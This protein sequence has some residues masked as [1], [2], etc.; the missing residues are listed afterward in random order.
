MTLTNSLLDPPRV[1]AFQL[2]QGLVHI[3]MTAGVAKALAILTAGA[4]RRTAWRW[5]AVQGWS[6]APPATRYLRLWLFYL[7]L[8]HWGHRA[9][10]AEDHGFSRP[11]ATAQAVVLETLRASRLGPVTSLPLKGEVPAGTVVITGQ[12]IQDG[13]LPQPEWPMMQTAFALARLK[14]TSSN[15][16]TSAPTGGGGKVLLRPLTCRNCAGGEVR[17]DS[18]SC[19]V[20]GLHSVP[21]R[22]TVQRE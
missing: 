9:R 19:V 5:F 4:Y 15:T 1:S 7:C 6:Q 3:A 16:S 22:R 10:T 17:V 2:R 12:C 14:L 20:W 21:R 18:K 8:L 11:I 13:R